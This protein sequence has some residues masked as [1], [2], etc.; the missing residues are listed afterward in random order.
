MHHTILLL[1]FGKYDMLTIQ[2]QDPCIVVY[3]SCEDIGCTS[4]PTSATNPFLSHSFFTPP[5]FEYIVIEQFH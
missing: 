3:S 2:T 1:D 4:N 5:T